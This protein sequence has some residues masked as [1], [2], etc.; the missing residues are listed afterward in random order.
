MTIDTWSERHEAELSHEGVGVDGWLCTQPE[1][2]PGAVLGRERRD[3]LPCPPP[4]G[5]PTHERE[6]A[7]STCDGLRL[8][9]GGLGRAEV[10]CR[11]CE[12][13]GVEL[14]TIESD[15][16]LAMLLAAA[17]RRAAWMALTQ[18]TILPRIAA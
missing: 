15:V 7:C 14:E 8:I 2:Q 13:T 10:E 6:T 4:T 5:A 17:V 12:G 18:R 16:R 1:E 9:P 3:T 11:A